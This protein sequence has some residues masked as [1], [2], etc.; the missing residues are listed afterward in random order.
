MALRRFRLPS[1]GAAAVSPAFQ[2]YTHTNSVRRPLPESDSSALATTAYT[3]DAADHGTAGDAHHAQFVSAAM[4]SGDSVGS[5]ATVK[6]AIQGLEAHANNNLAVQLWV[7]VYN[8]A[9]SSLLATLVS[10]TVDGTELAGSLTNRFLS[11]TT[12]AGYSFTGTERIVVEV[13]V[14]GT[15][16]G[17]GGTQGHNAS[18]RWGADGVGGDLGENDSDTGTTLNPW[19]EIDITT[20]PTPTRGRISWTELGVPIVSGANLQQ[21]TEQFDHAGAWSAF[22]GL[23]VTAGTHSPPTGAPSGALDASTLNDTSAGGQASLFGTYYSIPNDS[24]PY[25]ASIY[26]RKDANTSRF[27]QIGMQIN[28]GTQIVS[29]IS[30][31]TSTGAIATANGSTAPDSSGVEDIDANWWRFWFVKANN[32]SGNTIVRM[33]LYPAISLTL[34]GTAD[35]G[36]VDSAVFWGANLR[37]G[38]APTTYSPQRVTRGLVSFAEFE[39][40]D[41]AVTPTRGQISWAELEAPNVQTRGLISFAELEAPDVGLTPTRGL[42]SWAE[43]EAPFVTTRGL[44]SYATFETP[45]ITT[46]AP[47]AA[48]VKGSLGSRP[49]AGGEL[50]GSNTVAGLTPTR[51]QISFAELET[52]FTPT[53]GRI[54]FAELEV[55]PIPTRG[56]ISFAELETPFAPTRGQ[57]SFAELETPFTPTRGL[58]S[59]AELEAPFVST[60]GQ[61]SFAELETPFVGTRGQISFAE[62]EVPITPTRGQIS[63]AELEVP[64]FSSD[65]TRGQISFAEMETPFV[66]TRGLISF[67]ELETPIAPTRGRISFAELETPLAPTRGQVSFTEMEVPFTGTRGRISFAELETPSAPT[68][69]RIS[70]A[71]LEAPTT[72]TRGRI[73]FT[74]LEVPASPTRGLISFANLSVPDVGAPPTVG[75]NA[76]T[77]LSGLTGGD[78]GMV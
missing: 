3:P 11:T 50:A 40:P 60:R 23:T 39:A 1:S 16:G 6:L 10:K 74:E 24:A 64:N 35:S 38:E 30:I 19:F 5:G 70:W 42:I 45:N 21:A 17:G 41:A 20:P 51:G 72:L 71:E 15:P 65:P 67:A 78:I 36:I 53:R 68:R 63:F 14:Q 66:G 37:N 12:S 59:F 73:S 32:S 46:P 56:L 77:G 33:F 57:V 31:N 27:P 25:C 2:S 18:L 49:L 44:V 52:P 62:L 54:S 75:S 26:V 4:T 61:I 55:P 29:G 28:G 8:N 43:L 34:G 22:D 7:G 9:G 47:D 69:G 58:L 48:V 76:N 13:S